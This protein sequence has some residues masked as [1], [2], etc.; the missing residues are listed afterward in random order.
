MN[1]ALSV[2]TFPFQVKNEEHSSSPPLSIE[3]SQD[4]GRSLT[5]HSE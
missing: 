4:A 1:M 3:S 5:Q 2:S